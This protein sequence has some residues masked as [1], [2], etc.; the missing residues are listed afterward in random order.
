[1]HE[2]TLAS[3][4]DRSVRRHHP[5]VLSGA[6]ARVDGPAD[7]ASGAAVRVRASS[8]E[9]LG[10]GHYSPDS[11]I[12]VRMLSFG[13]ADP[14]EG[15]IAERIA[16][17][18]ARRSGDPLLADCDALRLVNAE[19][20]GLPGL[21]VDRYA[22]VVVARL[23]SAGMHAR[24][25][26]ISE[27]LRAVTGAGSGYERADGRACRREG[28]A[29]VEGPLWGEAPKA[30]VAIHERGRSYEV[31]VA[32]GQKTGFYLDQ[33]DARDLVAALAPGRR[34][35]DLFSYTGGFAVAA[36]CGG[37]KHVTLVD[38][39][40]PA[41]ER[42]ARHLAVGGADAEIRSECGDA[43][44]FVRSAVRTDERWDL[45]ILDPPPLA[46]H[47]GDVRRASRAYKDVLL[48]AFRCAAPDAFVLAFSCSHH[49]GPDLFGKIAFSAALDAER[50]VQVLRELGAPVDHPVSVWHP[51][52]RYLSGLLMRLP[53]GGGP[54]RGRGRG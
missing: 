34:V 3:G 47:R 29:V 51:E 18:A 10:Y 8:G 35:L 40:E 11:S 22:D 39:S 52:G 50:D 5:W 16:A 32:A 26:E 38:S 24:R 48:H 31:D 20:D 14:G 37:A 9:I 36:A 23:T 27:A 54:Q 6:V 30:A 25:E 42:A 49:V 19:G 17:A 33:R 28:V 12:R 45:L 43:F 7:G 1:M 13:E 41:L 2:V 15:L 21:V 46:R 53:G 44:S 4:R